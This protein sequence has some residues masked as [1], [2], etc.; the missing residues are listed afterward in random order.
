MI[1]IRTTARSTKHKKS[2]G[3]E[4]TTHIYLSWEEDVV[5]TGCINDATECSAASLRSPTVEQG[6]HRT[7]FNETTFHRLGLFPCAFRPRRS[8]ATVHV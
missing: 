7:K 5:I 4:H 1:A 8:V 6:N 2:G 3:F